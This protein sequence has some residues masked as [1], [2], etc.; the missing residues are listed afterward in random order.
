MHEEFFATEVLPVRVLQK[1]RHHPL[2]AHI[3]EMLQIMQPHQQPHRQSRPPLLLHVQRPKLP[4]KELPINC[5]RQ[6][7]QRVTLVQ[8][9]AQAS[10]IELALFFSLR[11]LHW[12]HLFASFLYLTSQSLQILS[13]LF[14]P[15]AQYL[16][17]RS[18]FI[19]DDYLRN[20]EVLGYSLKGEMNERRSHTETTKERKHRNPHSNKGSRYTRH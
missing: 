8:Q 6:H 12:S 4:F 10:L 2:I 19:R 5:L 14:H 7:M 9:R 15:V 20:D 3:V 11:T 13:S 18:H 1:A 16:L 17:L